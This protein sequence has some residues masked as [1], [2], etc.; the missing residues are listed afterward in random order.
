VGTSILRLADATVL[1]F[2]FVDY[3]NTIATYLE[4]IEMLYQSFNESP[5]LDFEP[6]REALARLEIAGSAYELSLRRLDQTDSATVRAKIGDIA[7]LNR[8]LFTSERA[9]ASRVGLPQRD[10]FKH[11]IYAP[12]LYTGYGV[13]TLPGIRESIEQEE[14]NQV[15][16]FVTSVSEALERLADQVDDATVLMHRVAG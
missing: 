10:W 3:A 8:L 9:L 4:E 5:S 6:I 7:R 14:W 15:T 1:P 11:L 13:K 2:N 12:G 16:A